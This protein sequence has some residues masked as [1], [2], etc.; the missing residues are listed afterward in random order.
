MSNNRIVV[1]DDTVR[2][3]ADIHKENVE[4][5]MERASKMNK[6][7][8]DM[9][10]SEP[11]DRPWTCTWFFS[12]V[13][14][15]LYLWL[16][17]IAVLS[18]VDI[19]G[20]PA[21]FSLQVIVVIC[22]GHAGVFGLWFLITLSRYCK[23]QK[24]TKGKSVDGTAVKKRK[25]LLPDAWILGVHPWYPFVGMAVYGIATGFGSILWNEQSARMTNDLNLYT[26]D[27]ISI[28]YL[29][30]LPG[31]FYIIIATHV[32]LASTWSMSKKWAMKKSTNATDEEVT[33]LNM[34]N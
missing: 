4:K 29:E 13:S 7:K 22:G 34:K 28:M 26:I 14:I 11:T 6:R 1:E 24:L 3:P 9:E 30:N 5:E 16:L 31:L 18:I 32:G 2:S 20:G 17:A 8:R 10:E 21:V 12:L 23:R 33:R 15:L 25:T 27:V 19:R